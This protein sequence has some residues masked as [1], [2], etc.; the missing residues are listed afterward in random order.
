MTS[1]I[2]IRV[3]GW[4]RVFIWGLPWN[5][6]VSKVKHFKK[7]KSWILKVQGTQT[8]KQEE[9]LFFLENTRG[10]GLD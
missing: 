3:A 7:I 9:K 4:T 1:H 5:L 6:G 2:Q 8:G 10:E